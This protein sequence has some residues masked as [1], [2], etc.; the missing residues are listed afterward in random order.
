M[1]SPL[2]FRR[3]MRNLSLNFETQSTIP[4]FLFIPYQGWEFLEYQFLPSVNTLLVIRHTIGGTV[5]FMNH[6]TPVFPT[7]TS[8]D[9][10]HTPSRRIKSTIFFKSSGLSRFTWTPVSLDNIVLL[11]FPK[12][13]IRSYFTGFRPF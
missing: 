8:W 12:C 11:F 4:I 10:C 5:P 6:V 2:L 7:L 9:E 13:V 3:K 1:E